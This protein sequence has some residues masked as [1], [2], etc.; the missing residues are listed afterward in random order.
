VSLILCAF[1]SNKFAL[2]GRSGCYFSRCDFSGYYFST[3]E[4][5]RCRYESSHTPT[6]M[7]RSDEAV[8][9][10]IG[11]QGFILE[12]CS[13]IFRASRLLCAG[14]RSVSV[15]F[16]VGLMLSIDCQPDSHVAMQIV[17]VI[18]GGALILGV[19]CATSTGLMLEP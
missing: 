2:V 6:D 19:S 5:L 3:H 10:P 16:A 8:W 17:A 1:I 7:V 18:A 15:L 12:S 4:V 11:P 14:V 9:I 13:R